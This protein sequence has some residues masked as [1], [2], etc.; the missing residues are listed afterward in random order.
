MKTPKS[1]KKV[2]GAFFLVCFFNVLNK[3]LVKNIARKQNFFLK[4]VR[5]DQKKINIRAAIM[6]RNPPPKKKKMQRIKVFN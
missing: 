2:S 3:R 4:S 6:Y 5:N 1:K